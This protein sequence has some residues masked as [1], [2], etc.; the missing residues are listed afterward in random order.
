MGRVQHDDFPGGHPTE[1]YS[2]PSTLDCRVLMGSGALVLSRPTDH[3][4]IGDLIDRYPWL[5]DG[6]RLPRS[7]PILALLSP[8]HTSLRSSEGIRCISAGM[9]APIRL[10]SK[11]KYN[12]STT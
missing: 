11:N 1:Y 9:I 8:K 2:R 10:P 5:R 12:P 4:R 7:S 3:L 6:V